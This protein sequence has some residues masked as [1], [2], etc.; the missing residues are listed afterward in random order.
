MADISYNK[1]TWV[2]GSTALNAANLNNIEMGVDNATKAINNKVD[3]VAGK[4]LSTHDFN[5]H[6][7]N[8]IDNL[9]GEGGISV[10]ELT[11]KNGTIASTQLGEI[12]ANP[13]NF[14]FKY[15]GKILLFAGTDSTTYQYCNN[16]TNSSDNS[17]TTKST[18]LTIESSTGVYTIA[19]N[20]H[21]VVAN[22]TQPANGGDL[23]NIQVGSKVYSIPSGGGSGSDVSVFDLTPY[24]DE[25]TGSIGTEGYNALKDYIANNNCPIVRLD[26]GGEIY[27][28]N[29]AL[30]SENA[31]ICSSVT[32]DSGNIIALQFHIDNSGTVTIS[33]A[34]IDP[35]E[36]IV[37]QGTLHLKGLKIGTTVY[38]IP[39]LETYDLAINNNTGKPMPLKILAYETT[40]DGKNRLIVYDGNFGIGHSEHS[41][42]IGFI[43]KQVPSKSSGYINLFTTNDGTFAI[44]TANAEYSVSSSGGSSG[45]SSGSL[46]FPTTPPTSQL[47]PSITTSNTQQ[48]LTVGD[49]LTIENGVLKATGGGGS[50]GSSGWVN[51]LELN[52][53]DATAVGNAISKLY[54]SA[55]DT[56]EIPLTT[57]V[58]FSKTYQYISYIWDGAEVVQTIGRYMNL[59]GTKLYMSMDKLSY[60]ST[61]E[62]DNKSLGLTLAVTEEN[63]VSRGTIYVARTATM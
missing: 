62:A 33:Q 21:N 52:N 51:I 12:N 7:K 11:N 22:S 37:E 44:L 46:T 9:Q 1:T 40:T 15:S 25:G 29:V 6:Y 17:V 49:G 30:Y 24:F 42:V 27:C 14:A 59:L 60:F 55:D 53:T 47:I 48:N 45:S 56:T 54:K 2:N 32:A 34:Q 50:G 31:F 10:I 4:G 8:A 28:F 5:D 61:F 19:E 58:D 39:K 18:L 13:Q 20:V 63:G 43:Y 35:V 41:C 3:K 26:L 23:I 16:T 36:G 57:P 38:N